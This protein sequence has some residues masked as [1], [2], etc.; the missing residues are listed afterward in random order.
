MS[1]NGRIDIAARNIV[2]HAIKTLE[3]SNFSIISMDT[4]S[5]CF[6]DDNGKAMIARI[7]FE[8]ITY[9]THAFRNGTYEHTR[10]KLQA[11]KHDDKHENRNRTR[12]KKRNRKPRET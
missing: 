10:T 3:K 2:K 12:R 4:N 7:V 5:I 11:I 6:I 8:P 9:Y 1:N